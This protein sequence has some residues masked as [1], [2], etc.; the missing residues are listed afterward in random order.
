M[1]TKKR[2]LY[3]MRAI[4]F[5]RYHQTTYIGWTTPNSHWSADMPTYVSGLVRA[6][7]SYVPHTVQHK[8]YYFKSKEL[9]F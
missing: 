3:R 5:V 7:E 8:N 6:G 2:R 1:V 4:T 9:Y